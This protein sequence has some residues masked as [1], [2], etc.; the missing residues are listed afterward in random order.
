MQTR[1][2]REEE[3][4]VASFDVDSNGRL[5]L[6]SL[7]A[8]FQEIAGLHATHL[9]IGFEEL[10]K[11]DVAWMLSRIKVRIES[12]PTW[13]ETVT[14]RTWPKGVDRL[15]ALRD[16][17]VT[18]HHGKVLA[19]ATTCWLLVELE[20][21]RPRRIESL[22]VDLQFP[23]ADHAIREIP[24]KIV[25]PQELKPVYEKQILFSDLDVNEHVNNAQYVRWAMDC[26]DPEVL[27]AKK[28]KS[29][30]L[31]YLGQ[32]RYGDRV[33]I[34]SATTEEA[35]HT[36]YIEGVNTKNGEKIFQSLIEW[37]E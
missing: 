33:E 24:D 28:V 23:G 16:F 18:S 29:I 37:G 34:L 22:N 10:R 4:P 30:Q 35:S 25:V 21:G 26:Y 7:F 32:A 31:N 14:L 15:F 11:L 12:L 2:M 27:R 5:S 6:P 3:F 8:R 9:G 13:W 20:K 17:K 19:V 36:A 1:E